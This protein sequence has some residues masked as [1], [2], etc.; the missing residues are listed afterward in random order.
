MKTVFKV[1]ISPLSLLLQGD[2]SQ[3][4]ISYLVLKGN[5][6]NVVCFFFSLADKATVDLLFSFLP[7]FNTVVVSPSLSLN[8]VVPGPVLANR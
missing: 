1:Y 7:T 5:S 3:N 2:L 4:H 8:E 6:V